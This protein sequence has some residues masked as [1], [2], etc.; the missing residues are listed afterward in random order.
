MAKPIDTR[1]F[2]YVR[3]INV[4]GEATRISA[5]ILPATHNVQVFRVDNF[6]GGAAQLFSA[7]APAAFGAGPGQRP[8]DPVLIDVAMQHI[9]N[10]AS[11]LGFQ[12]GERA[13]F[14]PDPGVKDTSSGERIVNAYQH[15]HGVPVFQMQ[16]SVLLDRN[17]VVHSVT[18]S[19]VGVAPQ[20]NTTPMVPVEAAVKM[21]AEYVA[22]P[23]ERTDAW[24]GK[25]IQ[26]SG[27]DVS[28]FEPTVLGRIEIPCQPAVLDKGPFAEPIPAYLVVFYQGPTTRLGWHILI[29]TEN[30]TEQYVIV[31]A[32]D[33]QGAKSKEILYGQKTSHDMRGTQGHVWEH[34]PL[35]RWPA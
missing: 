34:N 16:R 13:E 35:N 20:L 17:G 19:S 21:A 1:D 7:N 33:E 31:V 29:A 12:A 2:S 5:D 15:Y 23:D 3:P 25:K 14:V 10:A 4:H 11:A 8:S 28:K 32:A 18:G 6:T 30:W 22:Q 27:F 9:Q 26:R 24:T